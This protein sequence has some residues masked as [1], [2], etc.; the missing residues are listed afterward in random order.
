MLSW[1]EHDKL[2][3]LYANCKG[4]IATA[5]DE[6]FG[7]TPVEAM[8][9]G[10]PVIAANEGG[11]KETVIDGVTGMLI[12]DINADKLVE[13]IKKMGENPQ[14]FKAACIEQAKKFDTKI[15]IKKIKEQIKKHKH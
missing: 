14:K 13:A 2:I 9:S 11:Y 6:D 1:I 8:A 10:K 3:D 4:F 15:F 12:D 7:M 5:K